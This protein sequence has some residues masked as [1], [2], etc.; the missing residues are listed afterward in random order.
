MGTA[1]VHA[2]AIGLSPM[3]DDFTYVA[4]LKGFVSFGAVLKPTAH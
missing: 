2:G 3:D 1:S 4:T